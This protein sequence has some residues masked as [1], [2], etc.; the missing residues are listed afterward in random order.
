MSSQLA[1]ELAGTF[2]FQ[3]LLG[4]IIMFIITSRS[5]GGIARYRLSVMTAE[6]T[7]N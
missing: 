2:L 4:G 5:V 6:L 3:K 7:H 1:L